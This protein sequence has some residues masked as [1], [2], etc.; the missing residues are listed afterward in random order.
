MIAVPPLARDPA[1]QICPQENAR[2]I[3]HLEQG[4]VTTLLYGGNAVLYHVR[5]SEYAGLLSM[6]QRTVA[7]QTWVIP[8]VGPS[9]GLMLDQAD[10]LRDFEF[11]T[12][13]VLPQ[14][15]VVDHGGLA[16]GIRHF[17]ESY[18]KPIVLYLKHDRW[19]P[20][21]IVSRLVQDGL[22]SWI[23]YAVVRANPYEDGYLKKSWR[24]CPVA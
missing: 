14:A 19:L 1:G 3:R 11:P 13:M 24:R 2:L 12:V 23:K 18:G 10:I 7:N 5:L 9:F 17:A 21:P 8:S 22:V 6:L 4:G 20:P 15:E 16:R